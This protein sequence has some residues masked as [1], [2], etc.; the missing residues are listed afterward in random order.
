MNHS[1]RKKPRLKVALAC[2]AAM[3]IL[4]CIATTSV[5]AQGLGER[6]E[7]IFQVYV[8]P[9]YGDDTEAAAKNPKGTYHASR[10]RYALSEHNYKDSL[11]IPY[12]KAAC[13]RRDS[14]SG[15]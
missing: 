5:R 12:I 15:P 10:D 13:S 3:I 2:V 11:G 8:D 7:F 4:L 1:L 14:P 6:K 9:I